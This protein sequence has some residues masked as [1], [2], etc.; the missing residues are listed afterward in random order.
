MV[1]VEALYREH[2][3]AITAALV[4]AFGAARL[5]VVEAAVQEAFVAAMAQWG[6]ARPDNPAAW[7]TTVAKRRVIDEIRRASIVH[8]DEEVHVPVY[9]DVYVEDARQMLDMVMVCC[10]PALGVESAVALALRTVCGMS[11]A[12]LAR[13]LLADESA[14]EKRLVRA[15]AVL[16]EKAIELEPGDELEARTDSTMRALYV[17]FTDGYIQVD[18]ELCATAIRL[19]SLLSSPAARALQALFLLHAS[20]FHARVADGE[21]VPLELQDRAAWDRAMIEAGLR[22]LAD[23]S[24]GDVVTAYHLE[25]GIAACHALAPSYEETDWAQIVGLYDVLMQIQPSPVVALQRAIAVGRAAGPRKGLRALDAIGDPRLDD[26]AV[27]AAARG[28]LEEK[29]GHVAKARAAYQRALELVG[30]E[31]ERRFLEA[32]ITALETSR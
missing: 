15:R 11:I 16:R 8:E 24:N 2:A 31:P 32:R 10:H 21:L 19:C 23:A 6:E 20:R 9:E 5:D 29:L 14:V 22:Q 4:K 1:S 3:P 7:L 13:V 27:L 18:G 30:S 25:A 12:R 28:E 17:L 26:H